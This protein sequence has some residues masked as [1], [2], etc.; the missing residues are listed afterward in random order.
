LSRLADC[1]SAVK[2]RAGRRRVE[3]YHQLPPFTPTMGFE[4]EVVEAHGCQPCH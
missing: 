1:K 3:H 4:A 2:N